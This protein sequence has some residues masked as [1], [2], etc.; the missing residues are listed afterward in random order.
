MSRNFSLG[1]ASFRSRELIP[2]VGDS[3]EIVQFPPLT[4][5]LGPLTRWL[6]QSLDFRRS[7]F[8]F[9]GYLFLLLSRRGTIMAA[10]AVLVTFGT[11]PDFF[12]VM[13]LI[14]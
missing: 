2:D 6:S 13:S 12:L 10:K 4:C 14:M 8:L 11:Q 9:D 5:C 1:E 7:V 3:Y